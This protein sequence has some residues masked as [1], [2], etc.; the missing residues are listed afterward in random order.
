M[1][2]DVVMLFGFFEKV[3]I[4]AWHDLKS[5]VSVQPVAF[6][7][8]FLILLDPN[9]S[10]LSLRIFA[11]IPNCKRRKQKQ[12]QPNV[13]VQK[14]TRNLYFKFHH[15]WCFTNL[16]KQ[17]LIFFGV[18]QNRFSS[19]LNWTPTMIAAQPLNFEE[20]FLLIFGWMWCDHQSISVRCLLKFLL[21]FER[22]RNWDYQLKNGFWLKGAMLI[23][24]RRQYRSQ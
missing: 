23:F 2:Y 14:Q 16:I 10:K 22:K 8:L 1:S 4:K 7:L 3:E 21:C 9:L 18:H 19:K 13:C 24:Q 6:S 12:T 11:Q 17:M 20:F 15:Q 5:T